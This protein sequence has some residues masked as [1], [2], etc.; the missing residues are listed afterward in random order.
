[1]PRR[2]TIFRIAT[3]PLLALSV[4][5]IC[6]R[7]DDCIQYGA[8]PWR[9]YNHNS[10]WTHGPLGQRGRPHGQYLKWTLNS[11]GFRSPEPDPARWHIAVTGASETF[12]LF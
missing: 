11:A 8:D 6:A 3:W 7:V 4:L 1:M 5:E 10:L 12:R 2:S 9:N